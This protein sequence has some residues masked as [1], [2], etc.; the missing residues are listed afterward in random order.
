MGDVGTAA[1]LTQIEYRARRRS[2]RPT[3]CRQPHGSRTAS[4]LTGLDV[5]PAIKAMPEPMWA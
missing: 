4:V 3:W 5:H 2:R 1:A